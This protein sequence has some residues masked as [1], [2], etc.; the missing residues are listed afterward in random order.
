MYITKRKALEIPIESTTYH[1]KAEIIALVDSGATDNFIDFRTVKKLRLGTK[2]L[3]RARQLF[4]VDRTH[5]QAGFIEESVHLY[6]ERGDECVRTQFH[7][8]NLG[9]DRIIL[10]YPWLEVF[11]P[12]IDW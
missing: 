1:T 9:R 6:V 12:P 10:G 11:N 3:P 7:I 2:K 8:T 5:N 4:N